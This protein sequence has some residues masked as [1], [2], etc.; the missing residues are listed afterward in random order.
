M[1]AAAPLLLRSGGYK[2]LDCL[3]GVRAEGAALDRCPKDVV[4]ILQEIIPPSGDRKRNVQKS[5]D[6]L[7]TVHLSAPKK[8]RPGVS[9]GGW[10][11]VGC[12]APSY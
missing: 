7:H 10:W 4:T 8:N 6:F 2:R 3:T 9:L 12:L 11:S 1:S 5:Y